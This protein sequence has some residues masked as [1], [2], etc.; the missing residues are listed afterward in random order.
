[1]PFIVRFD[2]DLLEVWEMMGLL[3]LDI[4]KRKE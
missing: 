3:R 1:M 2:E 4:V